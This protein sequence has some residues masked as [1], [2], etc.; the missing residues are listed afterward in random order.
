L[1]KA[2]QKRNLDILV[3]DR[4]KFDASLLFGHG[5]NAKAITSTEDAK[6]VFSAGGLRSILGIEKE[7]E[8]EGKASDEDLKD[9]SFMS[10]EQVEKAM[11][12]LEDADDVVALQGAQKEAADEL[13][14][15]DESIEY[16]KD[17]E[18]EDEAETKEDQRTH[19]LTPPPK[20]AKVEDGND[21]AELEKELASWESEV[22]I[23]PSAI[24]ASLSPMEQYGLRFRST[25]DPFYSIFAVMEYRRKL[26]AQDELDEAVD[27]DEIEREKAEDELKAIMNGDL[28]ATD[29]QPEDLLRQRTLYLREKSRLRANKKRRKLTGQ[30]WDLRVDGQTKHPFWYNIDTG[31]A[32]WDKPSVLLE[33]EAYE[34][35]HNKKWSALPCDPL[36]RILGYLSPSPDRMRCA[37]MCRHWHKAATDP[38]FVRHVYPVEM[39]AY[40]RDDAKMEPNHYRNLADAIADSLPGDTIGKKSMFLTRICFHF[41]LSK[42]DPFAVELG[43]GHYWANKDLVVKYPVRLVGD[44]HNPSN[45]VV[46]MGCTLV[47]KARGGFCEG[48][49]FRRPKLSSGDSSTLVMLRLETGSRLDV[50]EAV[51]DNDGTEGDVVVARDA[52]GS[53][54]NVSIRGGTRGISFEAGAT[55]DLVGVSNI[56]ACGCV[57]LH[58]KY[59]MSYIQV[60]DQLTPFFHEVLHPT[61]QEAGSILPEWCHCEPQ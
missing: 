26:E 42:T 37:Q 1:A 30:D 56:Q 14:E 41:S 9:S 49:T 3:M 50:V 60:I 28:L 54:R 4:G 52:R 53:W 25:V 33:L 17:S 7:A 16:K 58:M 29:P 23:D 57:Q 12:S 34:L 43:D 36:I 31:E 39:G 2:Q 40:T 18:G 61:K 20:E 55:I 45:V 24:E 46:E 59:A 6:E 13:K 44:E 10:S 51:L 38:S 21:E 48:V 19:Q 35:A 8:E 5:R 27:M 22:G 32:V 15:F 47:W 11:L